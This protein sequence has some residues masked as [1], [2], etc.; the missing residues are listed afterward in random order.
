M[1]RGTIHCWHNFETHIDG[2]TFDQ[3]I[4]AHFVQCIVVWV[5]VFTKND[6]IN[7]FYS[8]A[9]IMAGFLSS[10]RARYTYLL[11]D[12]MIHIWI[13][14]VY[15]GTHDCCVCSNRT[16]WSRIVTNEPVQSIE[17][18]KLN[19]SLYNDIFNGTIPLTLPLNARKWC[20][21]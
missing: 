6:R 17:F 15:G 21:F 19:R 10:I 14:V 9:E 16:S 18:S 1:L 2:I 4:E 8:N 13:E 5:G 11:I 12:I 3:F 20:P 7:G